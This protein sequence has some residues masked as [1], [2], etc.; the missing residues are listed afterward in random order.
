[1]FAARGSGGE[2]RSR[3][4]LAMGTGGDLG[5]AIQA[6][7]GRY[8]SERFPAHPRVRIRRLCVSTWNE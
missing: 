8:S 3:L 5:A 4:Q 7:S 2:A 6:G 1:M